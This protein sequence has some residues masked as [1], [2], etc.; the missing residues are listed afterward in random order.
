MARF[1]LRASLL[2]FALTLSAPVAAQAQEDPVVANV[3]GIDILRS[4]IDEAVSG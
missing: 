2:A 1:T 3:N 4:E